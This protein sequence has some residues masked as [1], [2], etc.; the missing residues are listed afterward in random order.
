MFPRRQQAR[1]NKHWVHQRVTCGWTRFDW[2]VF[3]WNQWL[4]CR[5]IPSMMSHIISRLFVAGWFPPE[6]KYNCH[7]INIFNPENSKC[8]VGSLLISLSI[9][10]VAHIWPIYCIITTPKQVYFNFII[11]LI[12]SVVCWSSNIDQLGYVQTNIRGIYFFLV[13]LRRNKL[14]RYVFFF[15]RSFAGRM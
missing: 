11:W 14:Q 13:D 2:P 8:T 10:S 7:R 5:Y 12:N 6:K 9:K 4:V 1:P 3:C 15:F